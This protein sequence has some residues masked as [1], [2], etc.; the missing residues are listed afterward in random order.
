[1]IGDQPERST[2]FD[3]RLHR[4]NLRGVEGRWR[5]K[6][7][8]A[9]VVLRRERVGD[10]EHLHSAQRRDGKLLVIC[11]YDVTI[12]PR[13]VGEREISTGGRVKVVMGFVEEEDRARSLPE[14]R[15]R[16][17]RSE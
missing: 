1:M 10:D 17:L 13:E 11:F 8:I 9:A 12:S 7:P 16:N 2:A 4:G 5:R 14:C 6:S 15:S 3:P